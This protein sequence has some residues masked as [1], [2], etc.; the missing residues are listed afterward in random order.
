M[1]KKASKNGY[2]KKKT[3]DKFV[4]YSTIYLLPAYLD[5]P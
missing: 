4:F 3:A 2:P 5:V 1:L